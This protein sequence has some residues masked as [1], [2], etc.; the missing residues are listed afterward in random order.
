MGKEEVGTVNICRIGLLDVEGGMRKV[1]AFFVFCVCYI[2]IF[3]YLSTI[4]SFIIFSYIYLF[5][6]YR[7]TSYILLIDAENRIN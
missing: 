4:S 3:K 7:S 1:S 6:I 2:G 5:T